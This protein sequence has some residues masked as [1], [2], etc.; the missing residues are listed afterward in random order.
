VKQKFVDDALVR[1]YVPEKR[2][3]P[4][5]LLHRYYQM[6]KGDVQGDWEISGRWLNFN[7]WAWKTLGHHVRQVLR[8]A[9]T[10][11]RE[12]TFGAVLRLLRHLGRMKK[13]WDE[14]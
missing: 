8:A 4:K 5:W 11:D 10:S 1:H 3:N 7:G 12:T 14:K 6:G 9:L 2:C 13:A